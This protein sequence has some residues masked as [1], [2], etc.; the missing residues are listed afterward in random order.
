[1]RMQQFDKD[2]LHWVEYDYVVINEELENC[3]NQIIGYLENT[4]KYDKSKIEKHLKNL[5]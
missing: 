5:I 1:M 3:Y 4:L 2:V